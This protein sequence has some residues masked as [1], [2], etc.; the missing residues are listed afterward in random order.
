MRQALF[1]TASMQIRVIRRSADSALGRRGFSGSVSRPGR[2][3][4]GLGG[5]RAV[6]APGLP[7][8]PGGSCQAPL[9]ALRPDLAG[10]VVS[11]AA[12]VNGCGLRLQ[13]LPVFHW[14]LGTEVE[15]LVSDVKMAIVSTM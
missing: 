3:A 12:E 9:K 13:L 11:P 8:G 14:R 6:R 10:Q 15:T 4:D 7:E 2:R 5:A 1:R